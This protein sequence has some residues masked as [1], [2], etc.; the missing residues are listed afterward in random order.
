MVLHAFVGSDIVFPVTVAKHEPYTLKLTL[1]FGVRTSEKQSR[2]ITTNVLQCHATTNV[3][4][5][6]AE[7]TAKCRKIGLLQKLKQENGEV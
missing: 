3:L 6:H 7:A 4:Q 5:P 2:N 1:P